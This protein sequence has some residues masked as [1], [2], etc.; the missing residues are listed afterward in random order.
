MSETFQRPYEHRGALQVETTGSITA[1]AGGLATVAL[2]IIALAR[3]DN[4]F[5]LAIAGIVLGVALLAEGGAVVAEFSNVLTGAGE[6]SGGQ[7]IGGMSMEFMAGSAAIVLGILG[8][9]GI[10]TEILLAATVIAVGAAMVVA[11][12]GMH[13]LS[14]IRSQTGGGM[15]EVQ[16]KVA[17]AASS[18]AA[19]AEGLA[20]IAG[21][22]LG[23]VALSLP[24]YGAVL[25]LVG[26]LVLGAAL[27]INGATFTGR[28]ARLFSH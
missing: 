22:V 7:E 25:T 15:T 13:R 12:G 20:G 6:T 3:A 17:H 10:H 24:Q 9:V 1:V 28:V 23:I 19:S 27:A 26:L 4:G 16:A 11:A 8:L 18:N 2:A 21:I 5:L 14:A